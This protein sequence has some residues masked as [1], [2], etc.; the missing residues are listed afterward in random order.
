[1]TINE[2]MALM[3]VVRE[4]VF[5]LKNIR[6]TTATKSKTRRGI[7]ENQYEEESEPQYD[8][9]IIDRKITELQNWLFVADAAVKQA[10][11][12][13]KINIVANVEELLAPI[14]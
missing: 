13:T 12:M 4:R 5:D 14:E 11:A 2:T 6:M 7:G 10:N 1:M 8:T 9:K 3:K